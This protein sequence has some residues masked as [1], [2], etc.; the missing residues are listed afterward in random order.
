MY[1]LHKITNQEAAETQIDIT[2]PTR[3]PSNNS[4]LRD[5]Q[6]EFRSLQL[7]LT[8]KT[9]NFPWLQEMHA[10]RYIHQTFHWFPI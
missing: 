9:W 8:M 7:I 2:S 4:N 3:G 1:I 10:K 5:S 6:V